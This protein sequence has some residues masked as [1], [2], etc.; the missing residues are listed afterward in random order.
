MSYK[1]KYNK[2]RAKYNKLIGGQLNEY[3]CKYLP[4]CPLSFT[5]YKGN[6][7]NWLS[8]LIHN[9]FNPMTFQNDLLSIED[10]ILHAYNSV[11]NNRLSN[12]HYTVKNIDDDD[13]L[14][15]K[16][17]LYRELTYIVNNV[18]EAMRREAPYKDQRRYID[19]LT[20]KLEE[21]LNVA[22]KKK[23]KYSY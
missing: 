23:F 22:I 11:I 5:K 18:S 12:L 15:V 10:S 14:A 21:N 1:Y 3:D 16:R 2:Y 19:S 9:R 20:N 17:E 6:F 4:F 8:H 7:K 13:F